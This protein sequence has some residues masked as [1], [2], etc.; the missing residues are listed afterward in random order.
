MSGSIVNE[1]YLSKVL[2]LSEEVGVNATEDIYDTRG[3]KLLAKGA[4]VSRQLQER[5]IVHR[6]SKPLESCIAV[7]D[8]VDGN[9]LADCALSACEDSRALGAII[10][11]SGLTAAS[12][13]NQLA[14]LRFAPAM[15]MML[16]MIDRGSKTGL[17]H[18]AEVASLALAFA[19][20]AGL[21]PDLRQVVCMAGVLHDI[22]ELYID[23]DL[24]NA[25][26]V[27]TAEQWSHVIVHP[28]IGRL[29]IQDL[30]SC[31]PAVGIA[32]AEHHERLNGTGYP[33]AMVAGQSSAAG[34]LVASAELISGLLHKPHA[35]E[36]A[37]L[38]LKI[39]SGEHPRLISSII[40]Q[41]SRTLNCQ[42]FEPGLATINDDEI[43]RL[44]VRLVQASEL[45]AQLARGAM[46]APKH[47]DLMLR[48]RE[49]LAVVQRAFMST[50]L[51]MHVTAMECADVDQFEVFESELALREISWRVRDIGRDLAIQL[52]PAKASIPQA[53]QL[54]ALLC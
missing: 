54:L 5:L 25:K 13:R 37:E 22:G 35:L 2:T 45:A 46:I 12:V 1:H 26:Q 17:R 39:V 50:G 47:L 51:D 36:R 41:A 33:R 21:P 24:I 30:G 49:R 18:V 9:R 14:S 40:S 44:S 16:T 53:E 42:T 52:G 4:S 8:A 6:L 10:A 7:E 48:T 31:P 28:H 3:T 15:A 38:A 20:R 43:E 23:P 34:Q 11:A 29:L 19:T 32:V 27:L